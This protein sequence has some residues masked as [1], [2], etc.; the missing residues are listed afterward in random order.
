LTAWDRRLFS[1]EQDSPLPDDVVASV[2]KDAATGGVSRLVR[3][4]PD[5]VLWMGAHASLYWFARVLSI[6][7]RYPA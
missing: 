3:L 7:V 2:K 5:L 1:T 4:A 6:S